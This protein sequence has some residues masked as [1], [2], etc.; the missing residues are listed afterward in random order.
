VAPL[1]EGG[2]FVGAAGADGSGGGGMWG[3]GEGG[4]VGVRLF[5]G[6]VSGGV[7][8]KGEEGGGGGRKG[9]EGGYDGEMWRFLAWL[10]G[11]FLRHKQ[12]FGI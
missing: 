1:L 7:K 5:R 8:R 12:F 4:G 11:D 10:G 9:G 6:V 3:G 2:R